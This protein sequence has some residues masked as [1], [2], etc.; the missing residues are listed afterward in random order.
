MTITN[1]M[2]SD[3]LSS[4]NE[5]WGDAVGTVDV[6]SLLNS[7]AEPAAKAV[8]SLDDYLQKHPSSTNSSFTLSIPIHSS[9]AD[10]SSDN[11]HKN[12]ADEGSCDQSVVSDLTQM[13]YRA[14][15]MKQV[16][17]ERAIIDWFC[18]DILAQP[19]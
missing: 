1:T 11:E 10:M 4:Q 18:I 12:E 15:L 19:L 13:T 16:R 7:T 14:E 6:E 9:P 3:L 17:S 2:S 5:S 8:S